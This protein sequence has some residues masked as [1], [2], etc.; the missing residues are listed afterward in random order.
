MDVDLEMDVGVRRTQV[1]GVRKAKALGV[2]LARVEAEHGG[3]GAVRIYVECQS[4]KTQGGGAGT[5]QSGRL[6]HVQCQNMTRRRGQRE[7]LS[8]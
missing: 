1:N 4:L 6:L 3:V 8:A 5:H 2:L 7:V